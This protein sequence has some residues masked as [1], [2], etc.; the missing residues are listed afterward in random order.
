MKNRARAGVVVVFTFLI[1]A[2]GGNAVFV[3]DTAPRASSNTSRYQYSK[4]STSTPPAAQPRP[5]TIPDKEL[6]KE[7]QE[8][9]RDAEGKIGVSAVMLETGQAVELEANEHYP[10]QSVYKLPIAMTVLKLVDEG[11]VSL[12]Q[13]V[14]VSPDDFVRWGFHSPIRNLYPQGT[15]LPISELLRASISDSDGTANDVLLKIAGGPA[16]VQAYL[17]GLGIEDFIVADSEKSISKDWETQYRNWASP[18]AS[19]ELLWQIYERKALSDASTNL[20][21]QFMT[22]TPTSP[23]RLRRGLPEGASLAHKTG[24]GGTK[25]RI[26]GATND[27]GIVTLPNGQHI[28]IAVYIMDSSAPAATR[29]DITGKILRAA[30][31]KWSPGLYPETEALKS[32]RSK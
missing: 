12:D 16:N 26:T 1:A 20:L 31:E 21:L 28:A 23:H 29:N 17:D 27:I 8:L 13:Q 11:K 25:N 22:E 24:T 14:V 5:A 9:A 7:I 32:W 2:C 3:S 30:I 6:A 15:V 18:A 19:V 10:S 4:T